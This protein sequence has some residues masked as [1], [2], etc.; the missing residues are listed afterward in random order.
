MIFR[1]NMQIVLVSY[2]IAAA[3]PDALFAAIQALWQR[4]CRGETCRWGSVLVLRLALR[5]RSNDSWA[6]PLLARLRHAG[7]RLACLLT[8]EDRKWPDPRQNDAIDP[9]Q[10]SISMRKRDTLRSRWVSNRTGESRND[11]TKKCSEVGHWRDHMRRRRKPCQ[12]SLFRGRD[13]SLLVVS[14]PNGQ[15]WRRTEAACDE[16]GEAL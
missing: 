11:G 6:I 5:T 9:N 10:T 8:G 2:A 12:S 14:R 15:K 4:F 3:A 16:S 7:G 13:A 1:V